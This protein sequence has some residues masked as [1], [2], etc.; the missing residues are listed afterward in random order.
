M[1]EQSL[2]IRTAALGNPFLVSYCLRGAGV[3][4]VNQISVVLSTHYLLEKQELA[5]LGPRFEG[6][7]LSVPAPRH[8]CL[9]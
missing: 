7:T 9:S 4:L 3:V 8:A 2:R 1:R 5:S 6:T